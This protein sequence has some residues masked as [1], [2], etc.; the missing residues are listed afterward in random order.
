MDTLRIGQQ[1]DQIVDFS[2]VEFTNDMSSFFGTE[3]KFW[4][5]KTIKLMKC[6]IN[7]EMLEKL[8]HGTMYL[9]IRFIKG[10]GGF[11]DNL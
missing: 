10:L 6:K 4:R 1:N 8:F 11:N 3:L 9:Y 7:D 5:A 2:G